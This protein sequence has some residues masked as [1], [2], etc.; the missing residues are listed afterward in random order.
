MSINH[1]A[2][3][4]RFVN[5]LIL[6]AIRD[7]VSDIHLEPYE[8][9]FRIRY[10]QDGI[11]R[12]IAQPPKRLAQAITTH[13]K[14]M[15]QLDIS[16]QRLPQ[17]GRY[18]FF[19]SQR[20]GMHIRVSTCPNLFGEKIVLRLL[21]TDKSLLSIDELGMSKQQQRLFTQTIRQ[22]QGL[23]LVTGPTGSGKTVTQYSALNLLNNEHYNIV[24]VEDPVEIYLPGINQINIH[25]RIGLDFSH[26]LRSFLRQDPDI[27]MIG[28][29]RDYET[30]DIA[31]KAAQTGHL[32]FSTLHT[33]NSLNALIRL[34]NLGCDATMLGQSLRLI[35]AQRLLRR[36]CKHCKKTSISKI[37]GCQQC[38]QGYQG[39]IGIY[40]MLPI[41]Q[42]LE[43]LIIQHA[44]RPKLYIAAKRAGYQS[45]QQMALDKVAQG[46]T[47]LEE[48]ERMSYVV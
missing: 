1:D 14:V 48:V 43:Q 42:E 33:H 32:V 26:A 7:G 29:I 47:S 37:T 36:L 9:Q 18:Q 13:I 34:M 40:E 45:L 27:M 3:I 4:I 12:T 15:A 24:T 6:D 8:H 20:Q 16:E 23:I 10:R 19:I 31:I 25:Q 46:K 28:E 17:D 38:H 21:N 22:S 44:P 30:A 2:P 35:I 39:R 5:K 11:L 41:T